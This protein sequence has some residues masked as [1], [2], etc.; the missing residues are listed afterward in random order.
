MR[1]Y[2]PYINGVDVD[3]GKWIYC[4]KA[5]EFLDDPRKA[6]SLKR[7]FELGHLPDTDDSR[8][9]GRCQQSTAEQNQA[10]VQAAADA[11]RTWGRS[12]LKVRNEL[13][14]RFHQRVLD[15]YDELIDILVAEGHPRMLAS[16]EV[17]GILQGTSPR[18]LAW[19]AEQMSREYR[20]GTRKLRL[21]RKPDGVVCLN[22]PANASAS[23]AGLG[24]TALMAGNTLVVKAPRTTP[25]GVYFLYREIIAPVLEDLGAPPGTM[26]IVCGN[27][28]GV[29]RQWLNSPL[30]DDIM[31]FGDSSVG[32]QVGQDCVQRGKKPILELSGNDG[33]VIWRDADLDRAVEA[34]CESFYGSGQICMVPKWVIVHPEVADDLLSRLTKAAEAIRPGYPDD[35]DVVLSPVLKADKFFDFLA[36]ARQVGQVLTGGRR[37][38]VHGLPKVDGAFIEPTIVRLDGLDRAVRLHCV[39]EETFFPLLPVVVPEPAPDPEL[40]EAIIETLNANDYGL[41]NSL[42]CDDEQVRDAFCTGVVNGG[43]LKINDSHIG[44]VPVLA[45]HGGTGRTGGPFGELNYPILRTSHLQGITIGGDVSPRDAVFS[46]S[47]VATP[48]PAA[49]GAGQ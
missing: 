34:V 22:P 38:D 15:R 23:N 44:F 13:G 1:S 25:L 24:L 21:V 6:F 48:A 20:H 27:A 36:E 47:E 9:S 29:L 4:V 26:N 19:Y 7:E 3:G 10:A 43:M 30:V 45:T 12:P 42:W 17:G 8:V 28:Q 31:F 49:D 46:A 39:R 2:Q 40:A 5:A 41:R 33:C 35:P 37:V 14:A 16:W 11:K 32:L 18:T